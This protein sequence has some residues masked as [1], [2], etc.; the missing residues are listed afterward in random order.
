MAVLPASQS[1]CEPPNAAGGRARQSR[2]R[3]CWTQL[4]LWGRGVLCAGGGAASLPQ[5]DPS[6]GAGR[7]LLLLPL[8]GGL[9]EMAHL[10]PGQGWVLV[11]PEED[12]RPHALVGGWVLDY[13]PDGTKYQVSL[14][15]PSLGLFFVRK[16]DKNLAVTLDSSLSGI[17]LSKMPTTVASPMKSSLPALCFSPSCFVPS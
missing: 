11:P 13:S 5:P 7:V 6:K 4:A 1:G 2:A 9:K 16:R 17:G 10:G 15:V 14:G 8:G 12:R 3:G